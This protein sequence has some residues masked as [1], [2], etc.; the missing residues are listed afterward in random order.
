MS[1]RIVHFTLGPVQGFISDARRTRDLWAGSFL[2]SWLS[3]NAMAALEDAKGEIIFPQAENDDLLQTIKAG[4][5]STYIGSLP[6]R[7]KADITNVEG[8]AGEICKQAVID[9]WNKL[10]QQVWDR[11]VA[12]VAHHGN[13]TKNIWERQTGNFWEMSWV[14]GAEAPNDGQWLDL[15]KNWRT[16]LPSDEPGD[17][18]RLMGRYQELSGHPRIGD[19]GYQRE[20]W[21]QLA[22][23]KGISPLDMKEDERLC[24]IALIKRLFPLIA[25]EVLGWTPGGQSE[26]IRHWPSVSYIA[27][28]PWLKAAAKLPPKLVEAFWRITGTAQ[29]PPL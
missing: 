11:F 22:A 23:V 28:V 6:N 2:L 9:S 4:K 13:E 26:V 27:A 18:C 3:G 7:F 5:G 21:Q 1:R 25:K 14:T 16:V 17:K 19:G 8:D 15:R 10:H 20:F 29:I 12:G 24:S